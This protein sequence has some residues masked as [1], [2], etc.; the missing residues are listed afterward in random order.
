[1]NFFSNLPISEIACGENHVVALTKE[2]DVYTWG[3][4]EFGELFLSLNVFCYKK[5]FTYLP[6]PLCTRLHIRPSPETFNSA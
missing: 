6:D 1:M 5:N 3:S 4:G 2:E